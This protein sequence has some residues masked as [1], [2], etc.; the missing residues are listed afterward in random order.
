[1][2]FEVDRYFIFWIQSL[3]NSRVDPQPLTAYLYLWSVAV[4]HILGPN[5]RDW[6]CWGERPSWSSW[7]TWRARS[8]RFSRQGGSKGIQCSIYTWLITYIHMKMYVNVHMCCLRFR[9]DSLKKGSERSWDQLWSDL[10]Q[11]DQCSSTK[12]VNTKE[13]T[14]LIVSN[15]AAGQ[16]WSCRMLLGS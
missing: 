5:W 9:I 14:F 12:S 10:L 7:P 3:F 13:A 4:P 11:T 2:N 1:M 8:S 16:G 15:I 6:S